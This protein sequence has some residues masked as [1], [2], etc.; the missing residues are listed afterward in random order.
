MTEAIR[1]SA[2]ELS[3]LMFA[4]QNPIYSEKNLVSLQNSELDIG[5]FGS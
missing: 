1:P 3:P 4:G 2:D 5:V